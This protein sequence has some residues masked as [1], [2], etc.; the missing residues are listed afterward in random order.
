VPHGKDG[1]LGF[2]GQDDAGL[3]VVSRG[4]DGLVGVGDDGGGRRLVERSIDAHGRPKA[5]TGSVSRARW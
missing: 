4:D 3:V 1:Q 2:P 5:L